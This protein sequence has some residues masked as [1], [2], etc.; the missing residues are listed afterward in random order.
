MTI[1]TTMSTCFSPSFEF[2]L[3]DCHQKLIDFSP[4]V[5]ATDFGGTRA[6]CP[7]P[8]YLYPPVFGEDCCYG[9][10]GCCLSGCPDGDDLSMVI[11]RYFLDDPVELVYDDG[12]GRNTYRA[13]WK[14]KFIAV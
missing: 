9:Y 3:I 8:L 11:A 13:S 14:G 5:K 7:P 12:Q 4:A 2:V 10:P 6:T 1:A